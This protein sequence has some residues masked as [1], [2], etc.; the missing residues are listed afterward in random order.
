MSYC[1]E[2]DIEVLFARFPHDTTIVNAELYS[3]VEAFVE[4]HGYR[5][6]NFETIKEAVD[7]DDMENYYNPEHLN[8][9]GALKFTKYLGKYIV[10]N[11]DVSGEHSPALEDSWNRCAKEVDSRRESV[12]EE[13]QSDTKR[14]YSNLSL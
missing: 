6:E 7:I 14:V 2:N 12:I 9:A 11:Y 4:A 10:E 13:T 1:K 5:F 3:E 8:A